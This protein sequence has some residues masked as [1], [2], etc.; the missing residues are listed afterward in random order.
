MNK[1]VCSWSD[2]DVRLSKCEASEQTVGLYMH[3]HSLFIYERFRLVIHGTTRN[4]VM[5]QDQQLYI[6]HLI[7]PKSAMYVK[8]V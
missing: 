8:L 4:I 6:Y 7:K 5:T 3:Y 1:P 2:I